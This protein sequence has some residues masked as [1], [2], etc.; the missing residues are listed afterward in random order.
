MARLNIEEQFWVDVG[1][2]AVKIGDQDR[3]L[4][5]V[6]R[7]LRCAQEKHRAGKLISEAE[8]IERGFSEHLIPTFAK[9]TPDGI[10][11]VGAEKHFE[12]LKAKKEAGKSGGV[13]SGRARRSKPKQTEANHINSKQTNQTEPSISISSS[14]SSSGSS[15][16]SSSKKIICD[17]ADES[18]NP[19][20]GFIADYCERWKA[21]Y[22]TNPSIGGQDAGIAKRVVKHLGVGKAKTY[23]AEFFVLDDW[24]AQNSMHAL[25]AFERSVNKIKAK[26]EAGVVVTSA[27]RKTKAEEVSEYNAQ[28]HEKI[29]RGEV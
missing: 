9:R 8:F 15:S 5:N 29:L 3:A 18:A 28:M 4:G 22:G 6:L 19:T 16:N 26:I 7:F 17:A 10:K 23:L 11:A 1:G 21:K 12:W 27:R 13:A 20:K 25:S 14:I 24:G 2:V